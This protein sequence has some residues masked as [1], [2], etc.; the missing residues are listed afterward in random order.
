MAPS[1]AP[2]DFD[3]RSVSS[4]ASFDKNPGLD[5]IAN[6]PMVGKDTKEELP[7][8]GMMCDIKDLWEGES[9]CKCCVNWVEEYPVDVQPSPEETEAVQRYA[10]ILK[11]RKSHGASDKAMQVDTIV[12]QSPLLKPLLE[13]VREFQY[14]AKYYERSLLTNSVYLKGLRRL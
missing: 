8:T 14:V 12:V 1:I 4:S 3:V 7:S 11:H 5:A 13:E 2:T 9:K 6:L 10:L